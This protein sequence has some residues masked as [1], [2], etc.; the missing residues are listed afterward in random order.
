MGR[1]TATPGLDAQV[2]Q[3]VAPE[4]TKVARHVER[5]AKKYAPP[6]KRWVSMSDGRVRDTH[7]DAHGQEVPAN[8]RFSLLSRDYDVAHHGA[9]GVDFVNGPND[10]TL[11]LPGDA[12]QWIRG[13]TPWGCRC[14][15]A[16][17]PAAIAKR[18]KTG[19]TTVVGSTVRVVVSCDAPQVVAAEYGDTYPTPNGPQR[20]DGTHFM[21]R[22]A[23]EVAA[24][25]R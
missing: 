11:G 15:A 19:P 17:V 8:L 23:A 16:E 25:M 6:V 20:N 14:V 7:V 9:L 3:M 12:A 18:I 4:V 24:A 22:A 10:P 1:F 2:A 5:L 21:G 13:E